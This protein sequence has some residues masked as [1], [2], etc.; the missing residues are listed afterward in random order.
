MSTKA[1]NIVRNV[2]VFIR[3]SVAT[4]RAACDSPPPN[5]YKI[6]LEI[7]LWRIFIFFTVKILMLSPPAF[8]VEWSG[9]LFKRDLL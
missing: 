8:Q 1:H 5:A 7:T 6:P 9:N 4:I 2:T 3:L